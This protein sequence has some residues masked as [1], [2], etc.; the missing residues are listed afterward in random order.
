MGLALASGF[1]A[2]ETGQSNFHQHDGGAQ[3]LD[4]GD[5]L[6]TVFGFADDLQIVLEVQDLPDFS[7]HKSVVVREQDRDLFH[8]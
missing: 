2:A 1:E 8:E 3:F 4:Q 7:A 5:G 6:T